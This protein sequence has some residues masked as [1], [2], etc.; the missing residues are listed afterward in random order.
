[1][2]MIV[3]AI[4]GLLALLGL[5]LFLVLG[6]GAL[7]GYAASGNQL[8]LYF[9]SFYRQVAGNP[10]YLAI[11]LFTLTGYLLAESRAPERHHIGRLRPCRHAARLWSC[12]GFC[13][14]CGAARLLPQ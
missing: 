8:E 10:I 5:P 14:P 7:S 13:R 4:L 2:T 9:A 11:P 12:H 6:A 3:V 1:M